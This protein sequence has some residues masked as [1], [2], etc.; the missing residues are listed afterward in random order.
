MSV[1]KSRWMKRLGVGTLA[2]AGLGAVALQSTPADARVFFSIGV[3]GYGYGYAPYYRY[4]PAYY[5]YAP[6]YGYP[7]GGAYGGFGGY[8]HHHWR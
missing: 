1:M 4:A 7:Y 8:H 2:L 3:P 6:Y 5:G